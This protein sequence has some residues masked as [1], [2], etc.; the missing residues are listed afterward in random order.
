[1]SKR[2]EPPIIALPWE[3]RYRLLDYGTYWR[4]QIFARLADVVAWPPDWYSIED[5]NGTCSRWDTRE[6]ATAWVASHEA[7]ALL[8]EARALDA[9]AEATA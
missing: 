3:K 6:A 7:H 5:A 9:Q 8:D 2:N 4:V 1:M